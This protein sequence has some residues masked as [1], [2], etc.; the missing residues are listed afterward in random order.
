MKFNWI[1]RV[2]YRVNPKHKDRLF[3]TIFGTEKYKR[4]ALEL[5]NAINDALKGMTADDFNAIMN[6]AI[7]IQPVSN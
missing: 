4:Y 2:W 1:R 5:Y 3:C 7:K 6:D